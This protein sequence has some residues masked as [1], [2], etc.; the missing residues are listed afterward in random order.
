MG[1]RDQRGRNRD[2]TRGSEV[3][4]ADLGLSVRSLSDFTPCRR[5][6]TASRL[7]SRLL[8]VL[9]LLPPLSLPRAGVELFEE[10]G[11]RRRRRFSLRFR[12]FRLA[13][14]WGRGER[15]EAR[16]K[17]G[18]RRRRRRRWRCQL[19]GGVGAAGRGECAH[20]SR[21]APR[22]TGESDQQDQRQG[23]W[24]R[25]VVPPHG[26]DA[27]ARTLSLGR[28]RLPALPTAGTARTPCHLRTRVHDYVPGCAHHGLGGVKPSE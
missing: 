25:C 7:G 13:R 20:G 6:Q 5:L 15:I 27:W 16:G 19:L 3:V 23:L 18:R 24:G 28:P 14:R 2:G 8:V 26:T 17:V 9:L 22:C 10:T 1:L 4:R 11:G 12:W 21:P